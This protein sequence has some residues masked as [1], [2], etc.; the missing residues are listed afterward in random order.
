MLF[1]KITVAR[2]YVRACT[3]SYAWTCMRRMIFPRCA[4]VAGKS[5]NFSS[6]PAQALI[7]GLRM[8]CMLRERR[9][10]NLLLIAYRSRAHAL[11]IPIKIIAISRGTLYFAE[12]HTSLSSI[13]VA[14]LY[15]HSCA[16]ART[17][18]AARS[19]LNHALIA[20]RNN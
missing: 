5:R 16:L 3:R 11:P 19:T 13:T 10:P 12:T 8:I 18:R 1:A 15:S 2:M 17:V 20:V 9:S 6:L 14:R 7:R 4:V